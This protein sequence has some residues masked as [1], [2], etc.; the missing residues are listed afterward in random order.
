MLEDGVVVD[1]AGTVELHVA[2]CSAM[3]LSSRRPPRREWRVHASFNVRV[4][5]WL[6]GVE[7]RGSRLNTSIDPHDMMFAALQ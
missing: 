3:L 6:V 5:N 1:C 7:L 2:I 4:R